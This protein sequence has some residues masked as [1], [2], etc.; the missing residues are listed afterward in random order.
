MV[1]GRT[2]HW[3]M[4]QRTTWSMSFPNKTFLLPKINSKIKSNSMY[5]SNENYFKHSNEEHWNGRPFVLLL[6]ILPPPPSTHPPNTVSPN[7]F[8]SPF[9]SIDCIDC[10]IGV[11]TEMSKVF[12]AD[13]CRHVN[14][15]RLCWEEK[16]GYFVMSLHF[17]NHLSKKGPPVGRKT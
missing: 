14:A 15:R 1:V 2:L 12:V 8:D 7:L 6:S 3:T 17:Y 10:I 5:Y 13:I 11:S 9:H 16:V 4:I